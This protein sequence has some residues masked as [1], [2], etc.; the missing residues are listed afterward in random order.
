MIVG[1]GFA[2]HYTA[3]HLEQKDTL[4]IQPRVHGSEILHVSATQDS[5]FESEQVSKAKDIGGGKQVWGGAITYPSAQNYFI[6]SE[7]SLWSKIGREILEHKQDSAP[8]IFP[9]SKKTI[10]EIFPGSTQRL[11]LEQ[12]GYIEGEIGKLSQFQFPREGSYEII[13]AA[14]T[15]IDI[16]PG[17]Q[18]SLKL[19]TLDNQESTIEAQIVILAAGNLLNAC[20]SSFL[21]R[22]KT[23]PIGNHCSKKI[24]KVDFRAPADLKNI[25]QTYEESET[26]FITLG[27]NGL[28][29]ESQKIANSIRLQVT[30]TV[31]PQRAAFDYL[32][33]DFRLSDTWLKFQIVAAVLKST[34]RKKR[35]I[36][37]AIVRMMTDLPAIHSKNYFEIVKSAEGIWVTRIKLEL[38]SQVIENAQVLIKDLTQEISKS[39][40][41]RNLKNR[42][43]SLN[44]DDNS[45]KYAWQD[46]GH[47]YGSIPVGEPS[48]DLATVDE[49]LAL[50]GF[51]NVYSVGSSCFPIGSHG[52]PT[53]LIIDLANRLGSHLA[54]KK[55]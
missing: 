17:E 28:Q 1:T 48:R 21:T 32:I 11:D 6:E 45:P 40:K 18:Y 31:S 52:H 5:V 36:S 7:N 12:H 24:G 53:K 25:A 9:G 30:D 35:I 22:Q 43:I 34:L 44:I 16:L 15:G 51:P 47:Y 38:S 37:T 13:E 20:Y 3:S 2:A 27:N 26:N 46:A 41:L 23:F 54:S 39:K 14:I 49:N 29:Y 10:S 8:T 4:L 19:I 42:D 50:H 55:A 33:R